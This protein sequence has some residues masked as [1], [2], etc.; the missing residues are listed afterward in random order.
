M[1]APLLLC[2]MLVIAFISNA[3][4]SS[5]K[6]GEIPMEDM[7]MTVY[8]KD[9]SASAVILYDYGKAYVS[10]TSVA[11]NLVF[12]RHVRIKILKKE[13]LSWADVGI[14]LYHSGS[15]EEKVTSLKAVT[16]NLEGGKIVET[17]MSKDGIF[18]EKFN[19]TINLQKFALSNVREGSIIEYSYTVLSDFLAN[20]PNWQFQYTIPTRQTEYWA[21]IPSFFEMQRYMQGYLSPTIY[22]VKDKNQADYFEKS[23]H[24]VLDNVPAFK[25]EPF[26]TS[27]DDYVSKINFALA[28]INFPNQPTEEVMGT[29]EKLTK[30][31]ME[32]EGF[33]K[34]VTGSNFL[35][36]QVEILISGITDPMQKVTILHQYVKNTLEWDGTKD[37]YADNLKD[38]FERKKGT[39]GDINIALAS[40]LEKAGF[41][42]DMVL[43]STRDHGFIRKQYPMRRQLNYVVCR[44]HIK[45]EPIFLDATEK[46]LPV[47]VLPERCLNGEGLLV[48]KMNFGWVNLTP[49]VKSKS[50]INANFSLEDGTSLKGS[51]SLTR[52]GYDAQAA[53]KRYQDKGKENYFKDFL[54]EKTWEVETSTVE[55]IDSL[56]KDVKET[57][58]VSIDDQVSVAGDVAYLN[59]FATA[60]LIENPFRTE[61]REYPVDFGSPQEK[62]YMCKINLPDGYSIEEL[63]KSKVFTMPNNAAKFQYSVSQ[64]GNMISVISSMQIN[65]VL[66]AQTEYPMLREFYNQIIAKQSEQIVIRKN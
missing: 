36:K 27:V 2:A 41:N 45:D 26:M 58:V 53:R 66:F 52:N 40:M 46:F 28:Y 23:H 8:D 56:Q 37:Y 30:N 4:K 59:P 11:A 3:Q 64:V 17:K 61:T 24:W 50:T 60:Q 54:S 7:K 39:S 38:V 22:D 20:F 51:I 44:V 25:Q 10:A 33:G 35:K 12:E 34:A 31:L 47:N 19:R 63:P 55:N 29:W 18:K 62:I 1:R 32:S 48:S 13:G 42:V 65:K 15:T 21:I 16:Y 14:P 57:H 5:L 49:K 9:S 43:L 6:F